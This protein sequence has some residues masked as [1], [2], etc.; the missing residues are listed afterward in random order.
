MTH[1]HTGPDTGPDPGACTRYDATDGTDETLY[2]SPDEGWFMRR[3]GTT[4]EGLTTGMARAWLVR[5]GYPITD[6]NG[7]E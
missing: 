7:K 6:T 1:T 3:R 2:E 5:H 4:W